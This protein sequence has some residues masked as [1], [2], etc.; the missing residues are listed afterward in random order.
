MYNR[1]KRV[2]PV[3]LLILAVVFLLLAGAA[4]TRTAEAASSPGYTTDWYRVHVQVMKNYEFRFTE[5]IRVDFSERR[6]G[7]YRDIPTGANYRIRNIRVDGDAYSV[8]KQ[9]GSM[10]IRI[11]SADR[12]ITGKKT[13]TIHYTLAH[14]TGKGAA[15]DIYTD[16]LPTGWSTG[17][18]SAGITMD[19]PAD[20][21]LKKVRVY[22]GSYGSGDS[23]TGGWKYEKDRHRVSVHLENVPAKCG[24][25][26]RAGVPEG[27]WKGAPSI[28]WTNYLS[29]GILAAVLLLMLLLRLRLG[30]RP[31]Y[32][33]T[34][35]FYAP[36]DMNPLEV[37]YLVDG[38]VDRKDITSMFFYLA[39]KGYIR[40]REIGEKNFEFEKTA[41]IPEE[42]SGAAKR[43]YRGIFGTKGQKKENGFTVSMKAAGDRLGKAYEAVE[44][45]T[46]DSFT[47]ERSVYSE[48]SKTAGMIGTILFVAAAFLLM[49]LALLRDGSFQA[50]LM[51]PL[52]ICVIG[53]VL[54]T[55]LMLRFRKVGEYR[56]SRK[57]SS[58]TIRYALW[59]VCYVVLCSIYIFLIG[60]I[61]TGQTDPAVVAGLCIF[62]ILS[63]LLIFS[64]QIRS[65][66]SARTM[67]RL[68]GFR[69]FI[70]D[71][72]L[73]K[74]NELVEEDPEYFY[75]ILPYAY[76]LGL[77]ERWAKQFEQIPIPKPDWYIPYGSSNRWDHYNAMMLGS[78]I[79]NF[80]A[81]AVSDIQLSSDSGLSS[82]GWGGGF[83]GGGFS[84][85]GSGG[86]GGGAW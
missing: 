50:G 45:M 76:V 6:H 56:Y 31:Q 2:G 3:R 24:V 48:K 70:R 79:R 68:K 58:T 5:K 49:L 83:S 82:G 8:K 11:G 46:E 27:Y 85:G 84:G 62:L 29:I 18:G 25:T 15:N 17:I 34:V 71:A 73:A 32:T 9:D 4:E 1:R 7:I 65:D 23:L 37:G 57:R 12:Y 35:E 53:T 47:G 64:M 20:L 72:E 51:Q 13:Y 67:A 19:L 75:N 80:S 43:F 54:L 21:T 44:D 26:I 74:L 60:G 66:W 86:G 39:S 38:N 69:N 55:T 41:D 81:A 40:I 77:T 52:G 30:R 22:S 16:L 61:G 36:E 10:V 78:G 14:I 33:E 59:S 63:P 28:D 42:E